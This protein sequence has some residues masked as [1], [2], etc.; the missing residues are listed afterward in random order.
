MGVNINR[1]L[2]N[3]K[4]MVLGMKM[5]KPGTQEENTERQSD[6]ENPSDAVRQQLI[7][8]YTEIARLAGALAHEIKSPLSTIRLTMQVM[9]EDMQE[10]ETQRERR[11]MDMARTVMKQCTRLE[12]ILNQFLMFAKA[13][14]VK[15]VPSDMNTEVKSVLDFY[16]ERAKRA[17][18]MVHE[19]LDPNLPSVML[20]RDAFGCIL[21]NLIN[22]A[23]AAMISDGGGELI[24]R[25]YACPEKVA[26]E[27]I[28]NG[29]G[30]DANTMARIFDAFYTT[31]REGFG[32]GL[33]TVKK[34]VEAHH[35]LMDIQSELRRGT[36]FT[37]LFPV[38]PLLPADQG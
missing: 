33:P 36:K 25:T 13:P 31:K 27:L 20:D 37:L 16:R 18:I 7:D 28:D 8:D 26:L 14:S 3:G 19:Y 12:N 23:E 15:P 17:N 11:A 10:P 24:V 34:I 38:P 9:A 32:L 22:N 6:V 2:G 5:Q 30:M 1:L 29:C 21:W 4:F 35:G